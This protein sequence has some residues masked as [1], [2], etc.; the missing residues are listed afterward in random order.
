MPAEAVQRVITMLE[1]L[2]ADMDAE[3]VQDEKQFAAFQVW[4]TESEAETN[5]AIGTLQS[6][7]ETLTALLAT[8]Y[9]QKMELESTISR[10]NGEID[11]TR[12]QIAQATQ[13]RNEERTAFNAEQTDFDNSIA[14]CGKAVE[15]LKAFYGEGE[16]ELVKPDFM[17][18]VQVTDA[19]K[20]TVTHKKVKVSSKL[21]AFLQGPFDRFEA[22]SGEANNIVDQMKLLGQTFGEDKQSAID[23]ENRLQGMYTNLM[24]EKTAILNG[25]ISQRDENQAVLDAVNQDIAEKE[26]AKGNAQAELTDEQAYLAQVLKS[27]KDTA[28]LF[29][30]RTKDRSEEKMAT[31]EAIKVLNG[32]AGEAFAQISVKSLNFKHRKHIQLI[33]QHSHHKSKG[34]CVACNKAASLLSKA[35]ALLHSGTLATAAAATMGSDA[36]KDVITALNGLIKNLET[37]AKMEAEHK[38]WCEHEMSTTAAKKA[39][40]EANV[41]TLTGQ[42]A[43][44][45]ETVSEKKGAITDTLAAIGRADTNFK[46]AETLRGQQ[47]ATF[48]EEL[49]NYNDAIEALNQA[50]DILSKFYAAK[51]FVQVGASPKKIAP[52]VFDSAYEQKGG[53]G[54]VQMISTVRKEYEQ[55][56]SVL[57]AAEAQAIV[58]FNAA[59]AAYVQSRADLVATGNRLT[60]ELQTAESNLAQFKEDKQQNEDDIQSAITY[61]GQLGHSCATLLEHFDE[62]VRLRNEEKAAI[63]SAINVLENES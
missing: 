19:L 51:N 17:G 14:A 2:I 54:V 30:Q 49:Q 40:H 24:T 41:Q 11:V 52:G 3:Q 55:G 18:L 57:E 20:K 22:K 16:A 58:D 56:K 35:A 47:K 63:K 45:T 38:A 13:K 36:V 44:E 31:G 23:E 50:I 1:N 53:M 27:C 9:S 25:L 7:I 29:K 48:E 8:L 12:S 6:T 32:D 34:N 43:D 21:M 5:T 10:L 28:A 62:R 60:A 37:D 42:I 39:T 4:C 33:Q 61:L 26:T 15:I 59:K 46:E